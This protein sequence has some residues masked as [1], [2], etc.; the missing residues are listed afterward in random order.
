MPPHPEMPCITTIARTND[1][2]MRSQRTLLF[3]LKSVGQKRSANNAPTLTDLVRS[4]RPK[5]P[6]DGLLMME[7]ICTLVAMDS[8]DVAA[9][10]LGV[11]D[12]GLK[13]QDAKDGS[14]EQ[15]REVAVENPLAGVMLTVDVAALPLVIVALAG[16]SEIAKFGAAVIVTTTAL[17]VEG[18][19][20]M[21]PA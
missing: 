16:E 3:L 1:A 5:L 15:V 20:F 12:A 11:T 2:A 18:A 19:L 13:V 10:A 8:V 17:E 7:A 4:G 14:P 21:S 9:D 6:E